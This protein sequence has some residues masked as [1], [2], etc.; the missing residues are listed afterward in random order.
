MIDYEVAVS[1][2]VYDGISRRMYVQ[3]MIA[4]VNCKNVFI[5]GITLERSLFWNINPIYCEN[6]IIR[7]VTV[8]STEIPSGDGI[9]I[10]SCKDVLIEY[11]TMNNNDDCYTLKSGR[12]ND[13]LR[14]GKPTENVVI[15]N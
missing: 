4:A 14:G 13:G 6:V 3:K 11:C 15:R 7:G 5:E 10:E 9:D 1:E 8:N 12:G 2:R